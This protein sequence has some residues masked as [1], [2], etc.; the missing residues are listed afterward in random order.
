[1]RHQSVLVEEA[2][3]YLSPLKGRVVVD[4]TLGAGGHARL[5]LEKVAPRLLIGLDQD[6]EALEEAKENLADFGDRIMILH[7]NF[8]N[9][10]DRLNAIGVPMVDGILLDLGVSSMQLDDA[11]RG[12]SFRASAP[13]D[14]RM[15]RQ[16]PVTAE[17][18]VNSVSR[19]A[20]AELFWKFGEERYSRKIADKIL[21]ARSRSRIRTTSQLAA[22]I[23]E[24]VP[25]G[26][27]HG[28]IHPA[29]RSFQ[30]L[31]IFVNREIEALEQFLSRVL[32]SLNPQGRLLILSF[33]S[34]EDRMVK[35]AFRQFKKDGQGCILT[36]KP[37]RPG[38]SE[39]HENPRA[40][41]ARLRVFERAGKEA[42]L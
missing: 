5:I 15:N 19:E 4:G 40:R 30:A 35:N 33:H 10:H 11:E 36:K 28:R 2:L 14:M 23:S 32:E 37:V 22:I 31:R 3:E 21:Q 1:M 17:A 26:Y 24:A 41:S 6:G 38:I 25:A 18:V 9:M 20:L 39:V 27:R 7:E 34:L 8:K 12:F 16:D 42:A 29:T 13:L